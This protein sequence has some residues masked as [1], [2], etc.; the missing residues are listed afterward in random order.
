MGWDAISTATIAAGDG[1]ALTLSTL[2]RVLDSVLRGLS[3]PVAA[4]LLL[5]QADEI[6]VDANYLLRGLHRRERRL[7]SWKALE[8]VPQKHVAVWVP[9]WREAEVIR[10]MLE[11]NLANIDHDRARYTFFCGTYANDPET[12]HEIEVAARRFPGVRKVV[13]PHDGPTSKADCLNWIYQGTLLEEQRRGRPYDILL[14]HDANDVIHPL[15]LRLYSL[16]IPRYALVQLPVLSLNLGLRQGVGATYLDTLAE[17]HLKD[18]LVREAIGGLI[19]PAGV[20]CAF[21]RDAFVEVARA[22]GER[23]FN[24]ESLTEDYEIALKFRLAGKR[25]HFACHALEAT[26]RPEGDPPLPGRPKDRRGRDEIIATREAIPDG[27]QASVKRGSRRILGTAL[28]TWRQMGWPGSLPVLYSLWRDRKVLFTSALLLL[29]Y[30]LVGYGAL[31]VGAEALG[32]PAGRL[33]VPGW[34]GQALRVL[35]I[36]N[37]VALGWRMAVKARLV[38]HLYGLGHALLSAPRMLLASL[39][40]LGA[41]GRAVWMFCTHRLTGRPLPAADPLRTFPSSAVLRARQRRLG[42]ILTEEY[43]LDPESL[44]TAL[45]LQ[46][47]VARP[48][49]E[50]LS[51]MG[52]VSEQTVTRALAQLHEMAEG[53]PWAGTAPDHLLAALGEE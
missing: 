21:H 32:L 22:H 8:R 26:P 35:M 48:L 50:V 43:G 51:L 47:A 1:A 34:R 23:P 16:L 40:D 52:M 2:L 10:R 4:G 9:A 6:F 31:R 15:S 46:Q 44:E 37:L 36:V 53:D 12:Q 20:G 29:A 25:A 30:L 14:M 5:D 28:Q 3:L 38:A 7:I 39:L 41:T 17:R 49:G 24:V 33:S 45:S 11:H 18:I 27:L 42:E 19:P 13:V